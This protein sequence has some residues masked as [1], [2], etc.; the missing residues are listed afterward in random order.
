MGWWIALGVVVVLLLYLV[1]SVKVINEY[2]RG[3]VF[4]FGKI[5][6]VREP[7]LQFVPAIVERM[8][9]VSLQITTIDIPARELITSDSVTV[10]VNAVAWYKVTDPVAALVKV[11]DYGYAVAELANATLLS[12]LR[13]VPLDSLLR[14][15][16]EIQERLTAMMETTTEPWGMTVTLVEV[17]DVLL[18]ESMRRAMAKEA[19]AERER[20]AKIVNAQG[21]LE[22]ADALSRAAGLLETH[23][24]A[25]RLRELSTLVEIAA[26]KNS[27]IVFPMPIELL[28]L[29]TVAAQHLGG[30]HTN[31]TSLSGNGAGDSDRHSF[32]DRVE[33]TAP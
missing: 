13:E 11:R 32:N 19:E 17:R 2:E 8:V 24:S 31:G 1:A 10:Q 6:A 4:L 7:G 18:P 14:H 26:E 3:V 27:T 9:R 29:A 12:A 23:H 15:R 22:A 21:E 33:P 5:R 25:L 20:R 16:E 28:N 30:T